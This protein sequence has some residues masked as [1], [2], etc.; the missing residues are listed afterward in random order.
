MVAIDFSRDFSVCL[1]VYVAEVALRSFVEEMKI[2]FTEYF[3]EIV[4]FDIGIWVKVEVVKF[5]I[6]I[7][8]KVEFVKFVTQIPFGHETCSAT[9]LWKQLNYSKYENYWTL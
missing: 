4:I 2:F 6:P 8:A 5:V 1:L 7:W 9:K 3:L